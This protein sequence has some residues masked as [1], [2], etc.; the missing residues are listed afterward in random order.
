MT[1]SLSGQK[2]RVMAVKQMIDTEKYE[3]AKEAIELAVWNDKTSRWART[4]Y[5]KG[6]LCQTAYEAGVKKKDSKLTSLYDD[7]LFVAYKAYNKALELDARERL[8]TVIRQKYYLLSNDFRSLGER[9]YSKREYKE[10][11]RAFEQAIQIGES[12]LISAKRDTNLVFNA[13]MAA[14]ESEN[15]ETANK[16]LSELHNDAYSA[17]ASLLF[18]MAVLNTG[19]TVRSE[20]VLL[21]GMEL[22]QYDDS[23]VMYMVNQLVVSERPERAIELLDSAILVRSENH[24]FYWA[25]GLVYRRMENYDEAL[26]GFLKA[27]ELA[28]DNPTLYYHIGVCYYNMGVDLRESALHISEKEKYRE[29]REQYLGQFKEAVNWLER[30]YKLD[31]HNDE[32]IS[33]L[34]QL[35]YQLQMKEQQEKFQRLISD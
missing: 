35:Y 21:E 30:S 3:D 23:L 18:S 1:L 24:M 15:W 28:P 13:A 34:Y 14:Y 9:L 8:H 2:S 17:T 27:D 20:E 10:A 25:K 33:I 29:I 12:E 5:T 19:D 11:L 7:Q 4:Y 22:Y 31:P 16:Y 26:T 6:L 32:T